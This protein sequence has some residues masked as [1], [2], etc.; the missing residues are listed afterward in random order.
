MHNLGRK[1]F[2]TGKQHNKHVPFNK[3]GKNAGYDEAAWHQA[4]KHR[5]QKSGH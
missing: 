2:Y 1:S 5:C 3:S 4:G